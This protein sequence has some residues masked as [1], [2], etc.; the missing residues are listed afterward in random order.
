MQAV[1]K[2]YTLR[3]IFV[4]IYNRQRNEKYHQISLVCKEMQIAFEDNRA[5]VSFE[6]YN[7]FDDS[8][9]HGM[10]SLILTRE[11]GSWKILDEGLDPL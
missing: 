6:Q 9:D 11:N 1:L 5:L 8:T 10:K 7:R 2:I 3:V 4:R